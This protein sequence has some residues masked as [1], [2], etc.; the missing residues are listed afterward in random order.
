MGPTTYKGPL[1]CRGCLS[2]F[3]LFYFIIVLLSTRR[4][5]SLVLE[6]ID[7]FG[8]CQFPLSHPLVLVLSDIPTS[9]FFE[10]AFVPSIRTLLHPYPRD[11]PR[12]KKKKKKPVPACKFT[13]SAPALHLMTT[14]HSR[15]L[16][17]RSPEPVTGPISDLDP[18]SDSEHVTSDSDPGLPESDP[19]PSDSEPL[20]TPGLG[21][22]LQ[23]LRTLPSLL[24]S[25]PPFLNHIPNR[26]LL[27]LP[28]P[29]SPWTQN[30]HLMTLLT[31]LTQYP[32]PHNPPPCR[33]TLSSLTRTSPD[34]PKCPMA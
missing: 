11:I 5:T 20:L 3:S 21:T 24:T 19:A 1:T 6:S 10:T 22:T 14:R 18:I 9:T 27:C 29:P 15:R 23:I 12:Y 32:S 33:P 25:P 17:N 30:P 34:R 4:T 8:F 26:C 7:R 31:I 28:A 2:F 16:Q 13:P